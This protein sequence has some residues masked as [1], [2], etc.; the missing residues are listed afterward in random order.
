[1]QSQERQMR[2]QF[3]NNTFQYEPR[4]QEMKAKA[5]KQRVINS[6]LLAANIVEI[7]EAV[8]KKKEESPAE[9]EI[10]QELRDNR[11]L[12]EK[13]SQ[14]HNAQALCLS[15]QNI[16]RIEHLNVFERLLKLKLDNNYITTIE[17]LS[18]LTTLEWLDLSFNQIKKIE[19]LEK[20]VNLT[21]LSLFHNEIS[22]CENFSHLQNLQVLSLGKNKMEKLDE[23]VKFL[24]RF[25][26]LKCVCLKDNPWRNVDEDADIYRDVCLAYLPKLSFLDYKRVHEDMINR[27]KEN[28]WEEIK[29]IKEQENAAIKQQTD[30][31]KRQEQLIFLKA[32]NCDAVET[33]LDDMINDDPELPR[34]KMF[35][36]HG[37][38]ESPM[39][40]FREKYTS[41]TAEFRT[42]FISH[43][44]A[45]DKEHQRFL[46]AIE[47]VRQQT[48]DNCKSQIYEFQKKKKSVFNKIPAHERPKA[49]E[50]LKDELRELCD[51]LIELEL[52]QSDF[53]E[54]AIREFDSNFKSF[55]TQNTDLV[56]AHFGETRKLQ[57]TFNEKMQLDS[58]DLHE[59]ATNAS[60]VEKETDASNGLSRLLENE[61]IRKIL[62][63]KEALLKMV[64]E[65]NSHHMQYLQTKESAVTE[66]ENA[67]FT[68]AILKFKE[69]EYDR[70]V[71][72]MTEIWR[73]H[74]KIMD[75]IDAER[76]VPRR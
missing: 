2:Q 53:F 6:D 61:E 64:V 5:E 9:R 76:N 34:L 52:N 55:T 49:I 74:K 23:T 54:Q 39:A 70:N 46:R 36:A 71:D 59:Q 11:A 29:D 56:S 60:G 50:A 13:P 63:N 22:V 4:I 17:N 10:L 42:T 75:E 66:R 14:F 12:P 57:E 37:Y 1:M 45:R 8:R 48:N 19:G 41:L 68:Q 40:Q 44:E 27:A 16:Y 32:I 25:P 35:I 72:R 47:V 73:F 33:L 43:H 7:N 62:F 26:Q 31:L 18:T 51:R 3:S 30:E 24:R 69:G 28:K 20:L 38:L 15:Y 21:D 67:S 58:T 65:S